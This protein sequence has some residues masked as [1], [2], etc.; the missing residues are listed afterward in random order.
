[1]ILKVEEDKL[2]DRISRIQYLKKQ[3]RLMNNNPNKEIGFLIEKTKQAL[4]KQLDA[5]RLE[6]SKEIEKG[7][8]RL[9]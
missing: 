8:E 9:I 5:E 4:E 6:L 1:M 7:L 2:A 3:L